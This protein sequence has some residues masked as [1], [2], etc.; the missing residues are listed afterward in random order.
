MG[1]VDAVWRRLVVRSYNHLRPESLPFNYRFSLGLAPTNFL[2]LAQTRPSQHWT[3]IVAY[4]MHKMRHSDEQLH[5]TATYPSVFVLR[6]VVGVFASTSSATQPNTLIVDF[7]SCAPRFYW[8]C[9]LI[10]KHNKALMLELSLVIHLTILLRMEECT[11]WNVLHSSI[12][13]RHIIL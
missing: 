12:L 2:I 3:P 6:I 13:Y 10:L 7:T 11:K 1:L 4:R 9:S 8:G 5:E